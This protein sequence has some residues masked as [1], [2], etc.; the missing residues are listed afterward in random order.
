[1]PFI[2]LMWLQRSGACT[3]CF[4]T[5]RHGFAQVV[6]RQGLVEPMSGHGA[7]LF[8]PIHAQHP[9][10]GAELEQAH[11]GGECVPL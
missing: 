10:I 8:E 4:Y 9:I 1:M 2:E 11:V 6:E 7:E 3:A 5:Q